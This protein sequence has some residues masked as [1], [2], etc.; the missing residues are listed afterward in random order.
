MFQSVSWIVSVSDK[1]SLF[2]KKI[3]KTVVNKYLLETQVIKQILKKS[4]NRYVYGL[5]CIF[6]VL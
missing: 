6:R 3:A 5:H 1:L 2:L 4:S